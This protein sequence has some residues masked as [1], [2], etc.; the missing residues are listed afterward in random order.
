MTKSIF[1]Y[2]SFCAGVVVL[3]I[4][5]LFIIAEYIDICRQKKF[6]Q[7]FLA[8]TG[9]NLPRDTRIERQAETIA[10]N[11]FQLEYPAWRYGK[12]D[13]TRD[14]RRV[15][16]GIV[17]KK[18]VLFFEGWNIEVKTPWEMV[19]LVR[20]LRKKGYRI[21]PCHEEQ[22]KRHHLQESFIEAI[23]ISSLEGIVTKFQSNPCGFEQFCARLF[24]KIGY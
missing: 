16:N 3:A 9:V 13:G 18:S 4:F 1:V 7:L 20:L 22:R 24:Q 2:F 5:I 21:S 12:K 15:N 11:H 6:I 19:D 8:E 14:C 10:L 17:Y 23:K